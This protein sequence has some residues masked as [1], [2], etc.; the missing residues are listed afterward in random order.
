VEIAARQR[1]LGRYAERS[2]FR[3]AGRVGRPR[4]DLLTT[5]KGRGV[6]GTPRPVTGYDPE[7]EAASIGVFGF[8]PAVKF[9][10]PHLARFDYLLISSLS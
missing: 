10:I 3:V 7:S 2:S 5:R 9:I 1:H 8:A 4:A 6:W